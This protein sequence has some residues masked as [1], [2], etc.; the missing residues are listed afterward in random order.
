MIKF[1]RRIRQQLL[2]E[3]KTG[4]YLKY[5]IGEIVLVVIGILIA[6]QINNWNES[7]KLKK[8]EFVYLK[9]LKLDLEKDT[10]YYNQSI[11]RANLLIDRNT[12]FLKK[13]YEEQRS[14]EEG[15][16]LMNIP[17]WDS[18]YL[19]IQD[20]TFSELVSS[21]KL[22][23]ISSPILK[24]AVVDFYRKIEVQENYIKEFNEYSREL[25]AN[26]VS[27]HPG[28][29][30]QTRKPEELAEILNTSMFRMEDFQFLNSPS[31]SQFQALEDIVLVYKNK[32]EIFVELF[33]E[34]KSESKH[35]ISQIG[36]E[37]NEE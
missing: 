19:T 3:G 2:S 15:K 6:L 30:K 11:A 27:A 5:A 8:E 31:N 10:V 1:F 9:R 12:T 14:I 33:Q 35:L 4:K 20:N 34:L 29:I 17:L 36:Q 18:E 21:G 16:D 23:I 32:H 26:Y 24:V 37:L 7:N 13:I 22:N 25:M 28:T